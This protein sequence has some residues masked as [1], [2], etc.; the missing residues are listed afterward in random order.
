VAWLTI[1]GTAIALV[2]L[3][4]SSEP[5]AIKLGVFGVTAAGIF[6]IATF[7]L[8]CWRERSRLTPHIHSL[9]RR[10]QVAEQRTPPKGQRG[11]EQRDAA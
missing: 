7:H 8:G 4:R 11:A 6:F 1:V 10:L 9:E 5:L 2:L 3:A